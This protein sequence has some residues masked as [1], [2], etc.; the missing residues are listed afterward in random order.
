MLCIC[1]KL[2]KQLPF[3]IKRSTEHAMSLGTLRGNYSL[4]LVA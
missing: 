1:D 2:A 4:E 3:R